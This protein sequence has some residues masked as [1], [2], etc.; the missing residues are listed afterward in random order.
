MSEWKEGIWLGISAL[1][2][3]MLI[4]FAVV[5]G[6]V[7]K[8]VSSMQQNELNATA[9]MKEYRKWAQY[10]NTIV[11]SA[12]VIS[13]IMANKSKIPSVIVNKLIS[14][15]NT[16]DV[17]D[18]DLNASFIKNYDWDISNEYY[19]WDGTMS[20]YDDYTYDVLNAYIPPQAT[21]RAHIEKNLNGEV[22]YIWFK[23]I[24]VWWE[25]E[26]VAISGNDL[27]DC[28]FESKYLPIMFN[29]YDGMDWP[30]IDQTWNESGL[31]NQ[32]LNEYISYIVPE[33]SYRAIIHRLSDGQISYI[34]FR[35]IID[36]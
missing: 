12:E 10:D 22:I 21:Y 26:D 7:A 5:L 13:C 16:T 17:F 30:T 29:L 33:A 24:P 18:F 27:I 14:Y 35:R 4:T 3:A 34:E 1:L 36:G 15:N 32:K 6:G 2:T 11:S 8:E 31:T 9:Q 25:Y 28:I 20:S 23:R 19:L